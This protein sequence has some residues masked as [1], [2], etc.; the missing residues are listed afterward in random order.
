MGASRRGAPAVLF[1]VLWSGCCL[2]TPP[3]VAE[4]Q[5]IDGNSTREEVSSAVAELMTAAFPEG[6]G[7]EVIDGFE[8]RLDQLVGPIQEAVE[9]LIGSDPWSPDAADPPLSRSRMD[10]LV[11]A[12]HYGARAQHTY[13]EAVGAL[14]DLLMD[15]EARQTEARRA[16]EELVASMDRL[17]ALN[18]DLES[19][20]SAAYS[21]LGNAYEAIDGGL[22]EI[23]TG[24]RDIIADQRSLI[25]GG[26]AAEAPE[27]DPSPGALGRPSF[28]LLTG[29]A[30]DLDPAASGALA[31]SIGALIAIPIG[32][33]RLGLGVSTQVP[34][35]ALGIM[36]EIGV[37]R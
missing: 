21:A 37:D 15:Y 3:M 9:Q 31:W 24:Y 23:L 28:S 35:S 6:F 10:R 33:L 29:P 8:D 32:D 36:V 26:V 4:A 25:E 20:L 7:R 22:A 17:E 18:R 14:L 27:A 16:A 5:T 34:G 19:D 13:A 12:T 2:A 11:L 1:A 30:I